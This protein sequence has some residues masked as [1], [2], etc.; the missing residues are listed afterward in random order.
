MTPCSE[1]RVRGFPLR[2][3]VSRKASGWEARIEGHIEAPP[4]FLRRAAAPSLFITKDLFMKVN[5]KVLSDDEMDK[6]LGRQYRTLLAHH[7]AG[8]CEHPAAVP[9][10]H[11]A[12]MCRARRGNKAAQD[13]PESAQAKLAAGHRGQAHDAAPGGESTLSMTEAFGPRFKAWP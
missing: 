6:R 5:G 1:L 8:G 10:M 12:E 9:A 2:T 3:A 13:A 11:W 4:P 7:E